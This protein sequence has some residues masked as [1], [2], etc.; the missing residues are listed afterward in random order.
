LRMSEKKSAKGSAEAAQKKGF[1]S[2]TTTTRLTSSARAGGTH[3]EEFQTRQL[4]RRGAEE[5]T[6]GGIGSHRSRASSVRRSWPDP[7]EKA[8]GSGDVKRRRQGLERRRSRAGSRPFHTT[9]W[10]W[11]AVILR[12]PYNYVN[13]PDFSVFF[14]S[15]Q[16]KSFYRERVAMTLSATCVIL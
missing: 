7:A 2:T 4:E 12:D 5:E 14:S 9:P 16:K 1:V 6:G 15:L 11:T 3:E 13:L 8:R 10:F